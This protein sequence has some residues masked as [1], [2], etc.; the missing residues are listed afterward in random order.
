[1]PDH[2]KPANRRKEGGDDS[3]WRVAR[4]PDAFVPWLL[5]KASFDRRLLQSPIRLVAGHIGQ[6]REVELWWGRRQRPLQR[7]TIPRVASRVAARATRADGDNDLDYLAG[8]A[9]RY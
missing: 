3:R 4:N 8:D 2:A 9:D 5:S 6:D 1:M 7:S